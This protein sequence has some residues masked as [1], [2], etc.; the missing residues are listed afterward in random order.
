[1]ITGTESFL[2]L[3]DFLLQKLSSSSSFL[4]DC[5]VKFLYMV[6]YS[7]ACLESI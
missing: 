6:E 3:S 7:M 2:N 1:M 4:P 5:S